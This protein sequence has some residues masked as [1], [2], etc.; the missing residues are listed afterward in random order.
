MFGA[1]SKLFKKS[2]SA[3][4]PAHPTGPI[5]PAR[6][7]S[8]LPR[9]ETAGRPALSRGAAGHVADADALN[10]PYASIIK[11]IPQELWGKL[12]PAGVAGYNFTISRRSV[13]EQLPSGS[14]K[15]NFGELRCGAPAG[16]FINTPAEDGRL[17]D[18]PL[19]EIL[20]QLHPDSFARRPDQSRT[21]VSPDVPDLF[22]SKGERLA[23]LRVMEKKEVSNTTSFARQNSPAIRP[24]G[25][26]SL[27]PTTGPTAVPN[28]ITPLPFSPPAA[29]PAP[30][31]GIKVPAPPP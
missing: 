7:A 8:Q 13:L 22:G 19:S 16:V 2:E 30:H 9:V 24:A 11:L 25:P 31:S 3:P 5:A 23:P 20:A 1:I 14:V 12:A 28:N 17:V 6:S 27:A 15:V 18:L 29:A 4:A 26:I 21:E 10:I